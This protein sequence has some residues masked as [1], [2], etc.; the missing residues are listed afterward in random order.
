MVKWCLLTAYAVVAG[1][2]SEHSLASEE[3]GV[4]GQDAAAGWGCA[5]SML[6]CSMTAE[7]G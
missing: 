1:G 2:S 6:C 4:W 7:W 3:D 5:V